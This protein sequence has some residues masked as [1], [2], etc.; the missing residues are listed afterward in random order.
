MHAVL[1]TSC[2]SPTARSVTFSL[3]DTGIAG[4][5]GDRL[6]GLATAYYLAVTTGSKFY[7]NWTQP[8]DVR[9]Y[10]TVMDC[11]TL[12][13]RPHAGRSTPRSSLRPGGSSGC[14]T[15][16]PQTTQSAAKSVE[17]IDVW[18][19]FENGAFLTDVNTNVRVATNGRH[20]LDVVQ[21]PALARQVQSMGLEPL[22][23]QSLFRLAIDSLLLP[24]P[25]V[26]A[27][28]RSVLDRLSPARRH[29]LW[30]VGVQIRCGSEGALS[31]DDPAR[32]RLDDIPCF[33]QETLRAC[34]R[35]ERC[36]IFLTADSITASEVFKAELDSRRR[37]AAAAG[38]FFPQIIVAEADGPILHTDRSKVSSLGNDGPDPW[39]RSIVDWWLLKRASTLVISRSGFGETAAWASSTAQASRRMELGPA[40]CN[41]S[42]FETHSSF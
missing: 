26:T 5:F 21:T 15:T 8:Y 13:C 6:L 19:Y 1:S 34:G 9:D 39:L 36:P 20:W 11:A 4:G 14:E 22:S 29:A 24:T 42:D 31:W 33:V 2:R 35:R 27:S 16:W 38:V 3:P 12:A 7:V 28:A 18:T 37:E 41:V 40:K 17:A 23:R 10:F 30:Y 32:H 25:K